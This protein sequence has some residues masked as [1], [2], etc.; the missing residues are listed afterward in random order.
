MATFVY[1]IIIHLHLSELAEGEIQCK[2][3]YKSAVRSYKF[4]V[5]ILTPLC[6]IQNTGNSQIAVQV[7]KE[8]CVTISKKCGLNESF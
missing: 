3:W 2:L 8:M 6:N 7:K 1:I 4:D 5:K